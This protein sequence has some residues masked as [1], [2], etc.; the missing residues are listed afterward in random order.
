MFRIFDKIFKISLKT[1]FLKNS[2]F[3]C[4]FH[5]WTQFLYILQLVQLVQSSEVQKRDKKQKHLTY[6]T[7]ENGKTF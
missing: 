6:Y 1:G 4:N 3:F 7:S 5:I 2:K